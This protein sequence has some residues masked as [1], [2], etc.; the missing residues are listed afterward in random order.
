MKLAFISLK[1]DAHEEV[2][3]SRIHIVNTNGSYN[4]NVSADG[5]YALSGFAKFM[6]AF[7]ECVWCVRERMPEK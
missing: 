3:T 5:E 6:V 7:K 2:H 1:F 4:G